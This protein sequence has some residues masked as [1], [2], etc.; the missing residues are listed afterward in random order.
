MTPEHITPRGVCCHDCE[1]H[2]LPEAKWWG[3][4]VC[5]DCG[6]KRCPKANNHEN[7]CTKSNE[8]GQE[9]SAYP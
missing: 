5:R 2:L 8:P 9:G 3:M 4:L 6:N 1:S 7:A